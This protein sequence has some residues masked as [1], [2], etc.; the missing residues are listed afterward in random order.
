MPRYFFH[1]TDGVE[2]IDT[3]GTVLANLEEA[4]AEAI[5]LSGAMLRDSGGKFWNNGQWQL[6]V[7]DATGNKVCALHSRPIALKGAVTAFLEAMLGVVPRLGVSLA[8]II[9]HEDQRPALA[10]SCYSCTSRSNRRSTGSW[11]NL[12][13]RRSRSRLAEGRQHHASDRGSLRR[14]RGAGRSRS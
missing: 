10:L 1:V 3:E 11:R 9:A 12:S 14:T 8:L 2:T 6:R 13:R 7:V 5:V 4:R